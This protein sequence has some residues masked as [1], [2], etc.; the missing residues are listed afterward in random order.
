VRP[1]AAGRPAGGAGCIRCDDGR[2]RKDAFAPIN[3][4]GPRIG[5]GKSTLLDL[6]AS[7]K[8]N[9]TTT[10]DVILGQYVLTR[11]RVKDLAGCANRRA[12]RAC[13]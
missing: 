5:A 13:V 7:R 3:I 1:G 8:K 10:G 12:A 2:P 4:V 9:G 6:L 11:R